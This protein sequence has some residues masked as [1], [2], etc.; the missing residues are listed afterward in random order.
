[1]TSPLRKIGRNFGLV[2]SGQVTVTALGFLALAMNTRA[3]GLDDLG[4][5]FLIQATCE[6]FSKVIAFQNW[7]SFVKVGADIKDRGSLTSLWFFGLGL[8]FA[9]ALTA[10]LVVITVLFIAPGLVGLDP[11]IARLGLFFAIGLLFSGTATSVGA[12][13]LLDSFGWVVAI[14]ILQAVLL[15]GNAAL[16][17]SMQ[18]SLQVYLTTIPIITAGTSLLMLLA[19]WIRLHTKDTGQTNRR[20]DRIARKRFLGFALGVSASGTLN[21]IRQR[22]EILIVGAI[23]G[24]V[25]AALYG[26]AARLAAVLARFAESARISVYSEFS[27]LVS[28][29]DFQGA[30]MLALQ[31]SRWIVIAA[32][33]AIIAILIFGADALDLLFGS[34]Y[35]EAAPALFLLT[36]GSAVFTCTF[37]L[38]PLVQIAFGSWRFF[39]LSGIAFAGFVIFGV[40]GPYFF[41]MNGAGAGR[42]ANAIILAGLLI[43]QVRI[44]LDP[45]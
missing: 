10:T 2:L 24:P 4:R 27:E 30:K 26:I 9:A 17:L 13:R 43:W 23:L 31:L 42:A 36:T 32:I 33:A 1:M 41:G 14:N 21:V 40:L 34:D 44:P 12:L 6:L 20:F 25:G 39:L 15:L 19:A 8:D 37:A 18:A 16:L 5:L 3:L 29:G 11:E 22:G 35:V 7:Q 45:K 28:G 38:G